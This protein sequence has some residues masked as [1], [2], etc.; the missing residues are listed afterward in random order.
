MQCFSWYFIKRE[1]ILYFIFQLVF[2][3][4]L[5]LYSTPLLYDRKWLKKN[6]N[7]FLIWYHML[8][9][10][11]I[12]NWYQDFICFLTIGINALF[13]FI[14]Y[15]NV[16]LWHIFNWYQICFI[17]KIQ[18]FVLRIVKNVLIWLHM[19]GEL[20]ISS[21]YRFMLSVSYIEELDNSSLCDT[22]V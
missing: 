8:I 14:W 21:T 5:V 3:L 1:K 19:Q 11:N 9:K 10:N 17:E 15:L 18:N 16:L 12:F 20:N 4:P 13:T 22:R 6:E 2:G 7:W